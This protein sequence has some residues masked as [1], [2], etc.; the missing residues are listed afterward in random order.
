MCSPPHRGSTDAV[1]LAHQCI[2]S[3]TKDPSQELPQLIRRITG[4]PPITT[5]AQKRYVPPSSDPNPTLYPYDE[6]PGAPPAT[7]NATAHAYT[8]VSSPITVTASISNPARSLQKKSSSSQIVPS[9]V[10]PVAGSNKSKANTTV[11]MASHEKAVIDTKPTFV[12]NVVPTSRASVIGTTMS[13]QGL[14]SGPA[15]VLARSSSAGSTVQPATSGAVRKLFVTSTQPVKP[16]P[17]SRAPFSNSSKTILSRSN[18]KPIITQDTSTVVKSSSTESNCKPTNNTYPQQVPVSTAS[19]TMSYSRIIAPQESIRGQPNE[20]IEQPV[21]QI[22]KSP[23]F[24]Q[25]AA[26]QI[27]KPKKISTYSDAVGKKYQSAMASGVSCNNFGNENARMMGST[28][29]VYPPSSSVGGVSPAQTQS[30]KMNL[31]PGTRPVGDNDKVS[32]DCLVYKSQNSCT[33][34]T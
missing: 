4:T 3:L 2:T 8:S 27:S 22:M 19:K 15:P 13:A 9:G 5:A 18:S 6:L 7:G 10:T 33:Y 28:G 30:T 21:Q 34:C 14:P 24:F 25:E 16:P 12:T 11:I 23:T 31:A 26:T 32:G 17:A 1:K 29:S 20:V